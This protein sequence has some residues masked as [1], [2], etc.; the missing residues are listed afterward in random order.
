MDILL[1]RPGENLLEKMTALWNT[2]VSPQ[3]VVFAPE[4]VE[5]SQELAASFSHPLGAHRVASVEATFI[6]RHLLETFT[7]ILRPEPIAAVS[8]RALAG[9]SFAAISAEL[10]SIVEEFGPSPSPREVSVALN[11]AGYSSVRVALSNGLQP[12]N[13]HWPDTPHIPHEGDTFFDDTQQLMDA[14][15]ASAAMYFLARMSEHS[16]PTILVD[17]TDLPA[18]MNGTSRLALGFLQFLDAQVSNHSLRWA[19]TVLAPDSSTQQLAKQFRSLN[20]LDESEIE[21]RVFDVGL[22]LTPI[23]N[24]KRCS[25]SSRSCVRWIALQFDIIALRSIPHLGQQFSSQLAVEFQNA[26]ADLVVS[27]SDATVNDVRSFF[28]TSI[29]SPQAICR[30]GVPDEFLATE[31]APIPSRGASEVLV[32]G[33]DD[34]HKRTAET[35]RLLVRSGYSVVSIS[36]L[37]AV[38]DSHRVVLPSTLNDAELKALIIESGAVVFP[39]RYEGFG[40]PVLE[41]A[42][43]GKPIVA[44]D[45]EVNRELRH[46][47]G[48]T[49]L[50]LFSTESELLECVEQIWQA[51]AQ[52]PT[53]IR[54]MSDFFAEL[55]DH[56]NQVLAT[57]LSSHRIE[58]RWQAV[59][60]MEARSAEAVRTFHNELVTSGQTSIKRLIL[61]RLR[62]GIGTRL[63]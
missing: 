17:A 14:A 44:W 20:F 10:G 1:I 8:N 11:R 34:A 40:L 55:L 60:L 52:A 2:R 4:S 36:R 6:P 48:L 16:L 18:V 46:E 58:R 57:P 21:D 62:S 12:R 23:T 56:V 24:L 37:P 50:R 35:V 30:L 32:L 42:A 54:K 3:L 13:A 63:K 39:S 49:Q 59:R 41:A 28:G 33:N 47:L 53:S 9:F 45:S 38:S 22:S 15:P 25:M 19:I 27:I 26:F 31:S 43:A 51:P 29:D 5:I 61:D 7:P